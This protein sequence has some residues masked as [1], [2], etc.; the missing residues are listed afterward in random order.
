[1]E[2]LPAGSGSA[3][4]ADIGTVLALHDLSTDTSVVRLSTAPRI[5]DSGVLPMIRIG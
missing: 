3:Q 2:L 5:S 4:P 1:M